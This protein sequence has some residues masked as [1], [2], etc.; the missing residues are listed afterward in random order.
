MAQSR[1]DM[2]ASSL[3]GVGAMTLSASGPA[4]A[5]AGGPKQDWELAHRIV[6]EFRRLPGRKGLKILAPA[7]DDA[8]EFEVAIRP[9]DA[10]FVASAFKGFVLAEY[11]RQ[12]EAGEATLDEQL[13]L[14]ESVWSP[15]SPVFNPP[16]LAGKVTALTALEAMISHSDNTGT[17]MALKRAGADRVRD[18]I[19]S[20]G[21]DDARIPTSTRQFI[22]YIAG[23]P[24]WETITWD[25][26]VD[27]F[28]N[29]PFPHNPI[30]NDTITMAVSPHDFVSFYSR[31]LQ[32]EF[33]A[34]PETLRTFRSVLALADAIPWAFPLGVNAFLKGGSID[35]SGEHA[36]SLAGGMYVPDRWVYFCLIINWTDAE[37]GT[38]A[39]VQP[40]FLE[41]GMTIFTWLRDALSNCERFSI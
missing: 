4:V 9:Q 8:R 27:L 36:L 33:F 5:D 37:G 21:L 19:A 15:G 26:V 14:D 38:S 6:A 23:F 24:G 12:V 3:A 31:A 29:D 22:G 7:G 17:D 18:F 2:L 10:L 1:R 11:L 30:I 35:F 16:E 28:E 41:T 40:A 25:E 39:E 34:E 20:I 32:G 13:D